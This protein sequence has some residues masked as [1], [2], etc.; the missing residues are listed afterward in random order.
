MAK[1]K[2]ESIFTSKAPAVIGPYSQAVR[3]GDYLFISGQLPV[4]SMTGE[5]GVSITQQTRLCLHNLLAILEAAGVGAHAVVKTTVYMKNL[6]VFSEMNTIYEGFFNEP[7]P[8]RET[9]Q[10]AALPKGAD[11]E[12]SAIAYIGK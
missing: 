3:A 7:F 8:A 12:I 10:A 9:I 5:K 2:K 11:V 4:D 6:S 1:K